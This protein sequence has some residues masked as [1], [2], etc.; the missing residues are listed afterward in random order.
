[1]R[2][3]VSNGEIDQLLSPRTRNNGLK[4]YKAYCNINSRKAIFTNR[5]V[6]IWNSL[7]SAVVFSHNVYTFKRRLTEFNFDRC[8]L[9]TLCPKRQQ[10]K[11][12]CTPCL[13]KY[14]WLL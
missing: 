12:L 9:Y 5:V 14:T 10:W 8:L 1:L 2:A 7:P 4:L 3:A 6:D 13:K 11:Q